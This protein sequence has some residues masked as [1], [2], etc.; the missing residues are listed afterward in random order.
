[1]NAGGDSEM[2]ILLTAR[3]EKAEARNPIAILDLAAYARAIGHTVDCYYLDQ[4]TD[5][6]VLQKHYDMVGLSVLQVIKEDQPLKDALYLKRRFGTEVIVGGKWTQTLPAEQKNYIDD[7]GLKVHV[8]P[9]ETFFAKGEIDYKTYPAW[10]RIDFETLN[11]A[12][13]DVMSTRGCPYR[14]NF[15][16]NTE[17]RLSFFGT[18]RTADNIEL[19]FK[20]GVSHISFVDDVFT[21][22][23]AHMAAL[24]HE[25]KKRS[26]DIE[27]RNEFFTHVNQISEETIKWIKAYKPFNVSVGIESGDDRMLKLMG[28][29][30]DS[31]TA[32]D[33]VRILHDEAGV[34]IGTLFIIGFPGETI[35]SLNNTL[36]FIE[37]IRPFAGHWVSYYQPVRGTKGYEL[38]LERSKNTGSGRRNMH[39][40]YVEPGLTKKLLFRYNYK[41][42]DYSNNR[43]FRNR[44]I[45]AL[46]DLLPV[47]LLARARLMR[48]RRRLKRSM[49]C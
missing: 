47:W 30:F 28:K 25:L 37:N 34:N 3:R 9:G 27:G 1:V 13:A 23:S 32:F 20:L 46:I 22:K 36:H 39:I 42:M 10:D 31:K 26:I 45:Y 2:K 40:S 6:K 12:R 41:M 43:T 49:D 24:Y 15:C 38:A 8:G 14:C 48:Q 7:L 11:D 4:F 21:L 29:G 44:V 17:K 35:E 18:K 19:L 33:K 16:H 5:G